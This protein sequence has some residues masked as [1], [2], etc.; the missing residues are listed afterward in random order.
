MVGL[1]SKD[2]DFIQQNTEVKNIKEG[3]GKKKQE[4]QAAV[5]VHPPA[6]VVLLLPVLPVKSNNFVIKYS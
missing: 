4:L 5:A 1:Y 6:P 2:R 3:N